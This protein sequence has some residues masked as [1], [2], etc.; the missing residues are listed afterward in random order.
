MEAVRFACYE[1]S[2]KVSDL[3]KRPDSGDDERKTF[4]NDVQAQ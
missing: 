2:G 3:F 4:G 1:I